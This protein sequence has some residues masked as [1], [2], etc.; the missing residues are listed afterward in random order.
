GVMLMDL[1]ALRRMGFVSAA[2]AV[3]RL[4]QQQLWM[5]DQCIINIVLRDR[6]ALLEQRWNTTSYS[7]AHKG[8][9][10]NEPG[11]LHF[12][13]TK[14][15]RQAGVHGEARWWRMAWRAGRA[16]YFMRMLLREQLQQLASRTR[17]SAVRLVRRFAAQ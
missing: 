16:G 4:K 9:G 12:A 3:L 1:D 5:G 11:I 13:Q 8:P 7:L 15:W 6:M 10:S 14:P 17:E 2:T